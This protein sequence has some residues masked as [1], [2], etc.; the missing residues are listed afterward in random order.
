MNIRIAF[1]IFL[2]SFFMFFSSCKRST[3][4]LTD[5]DNLRLRVE[6]V[7]CTEA[8]LSLKAKPAFY[9]KTL[10]LYR[11]DSLL[12]DK[13]LSPDDTLF[14][15]KG[16]LPATTY[17][18]TAK[19]LDSGRQLAAKAQLSATTMDT[20][21]H[22]FTWQTYEFGGQGGSSSFYDVAIIDENDIWAVGEIYTA[23]D[24]YNAAHWDGEKWDL[25]KIKTAVCGGV[26]YPPLETVFS[27]GKDDIVF[28]D[29]AMLIH[30]DGNTF[31]SDC[32]LI[33]K[34][35]GGV[36]KIWGTSNKDYYVVGTNGLIALYD[37]L[38]W[39]RIESGTELSL[40]DIWGIS[41]NEIYSVG[42][43]PSFYTGIV[44]KYN[45]SQWNKMIES[46]NEFDPG[47]LFRTQLY[48]TTG[49]VWMDE[50]GTL[51]TVGNL[52]YQYRMGKWNYVTSLP[53]NFIG[54]DPD[55]AYR[56]YLHAV[57]GNASNDI[58]IFGQS[59]TIIHFNGM[60]WKKIGPAFIPWY[61]SWWLECAVKDDLIIGVGCESQNI[62]K[63]AKIIMI[64]K[65]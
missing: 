20:T 9:D 32:S 15:F 43:N 42:Y 34:L 16:L 11:N 39:T 2:F 41:S 31:K 63:K 62:L 29:G 28:S 46:P 18:F 17:G 58:F 27:F 22:D 23:D 51:Y 24:K 55:N 21:S 1:F 48:G 50:K 5:P 53:E 30:F 38:E 19:I 12:V 4:P 8:W 33:P 61:P 57:R 47:Q 7:S 35:T 10:R 40:T 59:N 14:Y 44:L 64:R 60:S 54:G 56:G 6:D 13:E 49:G 36:R 45:D 3:A 25:K 37:G 65:Q 26:D 52:M